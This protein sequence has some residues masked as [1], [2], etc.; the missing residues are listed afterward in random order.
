MEFKPNPYD[1]CVWNNEINGKQITIAFHVDDLLI[2][3]E[4]QRAIDWFVDSLKHRYDSITV[5][6]DKVLHYL[7]LTIDL[8]VPGKALMSQFGLLDTLLNHYEVDRS[9]PASTPALPAILHETSRSEV[10]SKQSSEAYHSIV[11]TLL[12]VAKRT[13]PDIL[14]AVNILSTKCNCPTQHDRDQLG[15]LL[16]YIAGTIDMPLILSPSERTKLEQS[17]DAAFGTHLDFKSHSASILRFLECTFQSRSSKQKNNAKSSTEAEIYSV[18]DNLPEGLWALQYLREQGETVEV[19]VVQQDNQ[20]AIAM[21]QRGY[22]NS[23]KTRHLNLRHFW[24][25]DQVD[26]G[27]VQI[28]YTPTENIVADILTKPLQ[29]IQF[30]KL[31]SILLGHVNE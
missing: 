15:R 3:C 1:L 20:S 21:Y 18:S 31:R 24:I 2:T 28:V 12:Y 4:D 10:L 23:E 5:H 22:S 19:L 16:S 26:N 11:A 13:R 14:L 7:G 6:Q 30:R 8:S 27:F 29:G 25:K 17:I 9:K